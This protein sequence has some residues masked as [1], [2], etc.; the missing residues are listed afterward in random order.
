MPSFDVVSE[1][2]MHEVTNSVDQANREIDNRFDLKGTSAKFEL[3]N[4]QVVITADADFQLD[5]L[6]EIFKTK[7]AK[8]KVDVACL[9]VADSSASG[10]SVLQHV[11]IRQGLE[12]PD[13]KKIVKLV[14]ESKLKVQSSIQGDKVRFSGKKRD[15]LQAVISLLKEAKIEMPLQYINFR[16]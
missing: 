16:D 10:K 13:C 1:V 5:Q 7:L 12:T 2:D 9:E 15:D 4:N 3:E 11:T 14:K 6:L 8:R